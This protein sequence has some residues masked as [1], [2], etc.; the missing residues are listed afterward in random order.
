[1]GPPPNGS[2]EVDEVLSDAISAT[3]ERYAGRT[4]VVLGQTPPRSAAV[5]Q[6]MVQAAIL[7]RAPSELELTIFE[8]QDRLQASTSIFTRYAANSSL[9]FVDPVPFLCGTGLCEFEING[10]PLYYDDHHPSSFGSMHLRTLVEPIFVRTV[11]PRTI[12]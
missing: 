12:Q 7:R 2:T 11:F 9:T 1:M 3:L 5:P 6:T 4:V 8:A 10:R